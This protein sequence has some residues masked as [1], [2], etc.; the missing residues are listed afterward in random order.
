MSVYLPPLQAMH[1]S[2]VYISGDVTIHP[3]A[4]IASGVLLQASP[5]AS[6]VVAAGACIGMGAV[7]HACEGTIE[8]QEG[9]SLGAGVLIVGA[10]TIGPGACIGSLSTLL[11]TTVDEKV[12]VPSGSILGDRS[13]QLQAEAELPRPVIPP[14]QQTSQLDPS[15]DP[16][17]TA[18]TPAPANA[19]QSSETQ[20]NGSNGFKYPEAVSIGANPFK[21]PE[22]PSIGLSQTEQSNGATEKAAPEQVAKTVHGQSYVNDLLSTLLPN[23]NSQMSPSPDS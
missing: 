17:A 19:A 12:M 13:R 7:L 23:R 6:I 22:H 4:A 3:N 8:I 10:G 16:W 15:P 11:N 9:A 18:P 5:G 21:Y 2:Q 1:D 20:T 14:S